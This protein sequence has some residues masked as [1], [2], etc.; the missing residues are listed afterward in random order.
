MQ[1]SG[2][3]VG[4]AFVEG[5]YEAMWFWAAMAAVGILNARR[6]KVRS[7]RFPDVSDG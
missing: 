3:G 4:A 1:A 2:S 5:L 6:I 7:A